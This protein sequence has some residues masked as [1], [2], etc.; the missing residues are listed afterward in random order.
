MATNNPLQAAACY[1]NKTQK[2]PILIS[3]NVD[4]FLIRASHKHL[5]EKF[6]SFYATNYAIIRLLGPSVVLHWTMN[7]PPG[8][9]VVIRQPSVVLTTISI[10]LSR[11]STA[12]KLLTVTVKISDH[13]FPATRHYRQLAPNSLKLYVT[14]DT[15]S[16][17]RGLISHLSPAA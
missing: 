1:P 6:H 2:G 7:F 4:D 10:F 14:Y 5:I 15:Y 13:Q 16:T 17:T 11:P 12:A 9:R 3:V 8:R